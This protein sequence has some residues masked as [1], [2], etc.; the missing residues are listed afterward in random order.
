M[1]YESVECDT[2]HRIR[3]QKCW[4][5]LLL[6]IPSEASLVQAVVSCFDYCGC[7]LTSVL[8]ESLPCEN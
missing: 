2:W 3:V 4:L 5:L 6:S 8:S 1:L 7:L